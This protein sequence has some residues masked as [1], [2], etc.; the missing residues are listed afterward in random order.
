[1]SLFS[2][3]P[4]IT[5]LRAVQENKNPVFVR[6]S[7]LVASSHKNFGVL[8]SRI[9][10]ILQIDL[11]LLTH[12]QE[13]KLQIFAGNEATSLTLERNRGSVSNIYAQSNIY[14]TDS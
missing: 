10:L 12:S 9:S 4:T 6:R 1:M 2:D 13:V 5:T 11:F 7:D 14:Q 3:S 8:I